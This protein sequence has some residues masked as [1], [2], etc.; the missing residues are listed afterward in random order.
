MM[1][2]PRLRGDVEEVAVVEDP[3]QDLVHVVGRVV[4]VR[5]DRVELQVGRRDLRLQPG[6]D[7]RRLVEAVRRQE[8]QE[9]AHVLERGGLGVHHLVDVAVAGLGVGAAELVE[10]DVL[11]GDFLDHVRPGDEE[12]ALV[13][14]RDQQVVLDRRIHRSPSAFA[15]DEG[16]LRHQPG[17]QLV[18]AAQ[19]GVPGQRGDRVLDAGAAG[20]VDADDRAPDHRAPL[21]QPGH[22]AAEH[23]ADRALEHRLVVGEHPDRP[24][25]DHAVAGDARRRRRARS[26]RSAS[27]PARRSPGSCPGRPARGCGRGRSG[28]PSCRAWRRPSHHRAPWPAPA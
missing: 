2:G 13:A 16:D 10:G 3:Q 26:G 24:A 14:H 25:V 11:A 4:G 8:R 27:W 22:L 6:I 20:V 23:L 28:C 1:A 21:H 5:H 18:A 9:V 15:E 12:V 7:D 17:Q 19:L